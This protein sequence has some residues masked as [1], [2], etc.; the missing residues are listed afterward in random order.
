MIGIKRLE[1]GSDHTFDLIEKSRE[2]INQLVVVFFNFVM[3]SK[4]Q[5]SIKRFSQIWL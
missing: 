1:L 3:Q 4:W 5:S 2:T